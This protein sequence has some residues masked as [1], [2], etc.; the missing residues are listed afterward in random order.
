M[1]RSGIQ[2]HCNLAVQD[3]NLVLTLVFPCGI[4]ERLVPHVRNALCALNGLEADAVL[5][6]IAPDGDDAV[7]NRDLLQ[8]PVV[9]KCAVID[10]RHDSS[11]D[12]LRNLD[13]FHCRTAGNC[14]ISQHIQLIIDCT[15][16]IRMA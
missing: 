4:E 14:N 11:V 16:G 1:G 7:R 8:C 13:F 15:I 6:G 5:K 9:P 2:R 3:D 10:L 12:H